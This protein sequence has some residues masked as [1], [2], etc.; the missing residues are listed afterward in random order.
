MKMGERGE[1]M[2]EAGRDKNTSSSSNNFN[3]IVEIEDGQARSGN[4]ARWVK[5][6]LCFFFFFLEGSPASSKSTQPKE[7]REKV[8][9]LLLSFMIRLPEFG[10]FSCRANMPRKQGDSKTS[11]KK[12]AKN[13]KTKPHSGSC[14]SYLIFCRFYLI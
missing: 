9:G 12:G 5:G 2:R 14:V 7:G 11:R 13:F 6:E 8:P 1:G 4:G 3:I 10:A